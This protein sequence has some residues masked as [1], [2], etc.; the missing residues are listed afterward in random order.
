MKGKEDLADK[1]GTWP[2]KQSGGGVTSDI[3]S[4]FVSERR[5]NQRLA[6]QGAVKRPYSANAVIGC[7][8]VKG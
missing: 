8:L 7:L 2:E 5:Q 4:H 3:R 1:C 6:F